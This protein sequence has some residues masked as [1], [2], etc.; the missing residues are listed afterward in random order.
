MAEGERW[1]LTLFGGFT[2]NC[3]KSPV[4]LSGKMT[5]TL[6]AW[7][8]LNRRPLSREQ[9]LNTLRLASLDGETT[10]SNFRWHLAAIRKALGVK[11]KADNDPFFED[12]NRT[13]LLQTRWV[14]TDVED[15]EATYERGMQCQEMSTRAEHFAH[16]VRTYTGELL[17]GFTAEI[18]E[19]ARDKYA[20]IYLDALYHLALSY[21]RCRHPHALPLV[22][23]VLKE[24]PFHEK[25]TELLAHLSLHVN[26]DRAEAIATLEKLGRHLFDRE[27]V[28]A[29]SAFDLLSQL[30][31]N[32]EQVPDG[33]YV[34]IALP[35]LSD[36]LGLREESVAP[37][38]RATHLSPFVG[39]TQE[40]QM[41]CQAIT[42]GM[43]AGTLPLEKRLLNLW[44]TGGSGK[45]RLAHQVSQE[46]KRRFPNRVA[47]VRVETTDRL[48]H[49][50]ARILQT[51]QP[52]S[53]PRGDAGKSLLA[54]LAAQTEP[55]LIVLDN[56][57]H[58]IDRVQHEHAEHPLTEWLVTLLSRSERLVVLLTARQQLHPGRHSL[59]LTSLS[60]P[61]E[62][63]SF[64]TIQS[65]ACVQLFCNI[66]SRNG[67]LL[68]DQNAPLVARLCRALD[69]LP[70]AI[71]LAATRTEDMPLNAMLSRISHRLDW[72]KEDSSFGGEPRH[73]SLWAA[74]ADSY[75]FLLP[76]EQQLLGRLSVFEGFWD[77]EAVMAVLETGGD[78]KQVRTCL[79]VLTR[80]ALVQRETRD[81][82]II[83]RLL[84]TIREC[85]HEKL[86]QEP[87]AETTQLARNHARYFR[88]FAEHSVEFY[89][90][91]HEKDRIDRL[92]ANHENLCAA[93]QWHA[94]HAEAA[95]GWLALIT[96]LGPFWHRR[97]YSREIWK[98]CHVFLNQVA[99][100]S[101]TPDR[102]LAYT[103]A[104]ECALL[105]GDAA[106]FSDL[107]AKSKTDFEQLHDANGLARIHLLQGKWEH[108][109]GA[110][111]RAHQEY[112]AALAFCRQAERKNIGLQAQILNNQGNALFK[113][114]ESAREAEQC[115]E[116]SLKM[117]EEL[118]HEIAI[119]ET[120][121]NLGDLASH[122]REYLRAQH[123]WEECL[124]IQERWQQPRDIAITLNNLGCM[125]Q[126]MRDYPRARAYHVRALQIRKELYHVEGMASSFCNLGLVDYCEGQYASAWQNFAESLPLHAKIQQTS[127]MAVI[128]SQLAHIAVAQNQPIQAAYLWGMTAALR[129]LNEI[130]RDYTADEQADYDHKRMRVQ[131]QIGSERQRE[132]EDQGE[133]TV[134]EAKSKNEIVSKILE[135][136]RWMEFPTLETVVR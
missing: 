134:R 63:A 15:L 125:A 34:E 68:T 106:A 123:Y 105:S 3:G 37:A 79:H 18:F 59:L 21:A 50:P 1:H 82:M 112:T 43:E 99:P 85:A 83:Y 14:S 101:V 110:F 76:A 95:A 88:Q 64:D 122:Q 108:Q 77:S 131:Q 49:L 39:R 11:A 120:K 17:P 136:V 71:E 51:M 13:L 75:D 20:G 87:K 103:Q 58:L 69:G 98:W 124:P 70:L 35:S 100:E 60:S 27:A 12:K 28:L 80:Y 56:C 38:S 65:D 62:L 129:P 133:Q 94:C 32:R 55:T 40:T 45:T 121:S 29:S 109:Q 41:L 115:L 111:D 9:W 6:L 127:I 73:K 93:L 126:V 48:E 92:E 30:Q 86:E 5:Q 61:Q 24:A 90:G 42:E 31:D 26:N 53:S 89:A 119:A 19:T 16:V 118:G 78:T 74:F 135:T 128:A 72:V 107:L 23:K 57:D 46:L 117:R 2:V 7:M 22:R 91:P 97:G 44:G 25:A 47:F 132:W 66:A 102:A 113:L 4:R 84:D 114:P 54:V 52:G 116:E 104:A 130:R 96:A 36:I 33:F 67:F 10:P 81:N 8:A